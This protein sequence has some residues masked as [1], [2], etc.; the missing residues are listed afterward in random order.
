M[1]YTADTQLDLTQIFFEYEVKFQEFFQVL[2]KEERKVYSMIIENNSKDAN[3]IET[4]IACPKRV[5][6][7][8]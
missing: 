2:I 1:Y 4:A 6:Q 3:N 5:L 8:R 7:I